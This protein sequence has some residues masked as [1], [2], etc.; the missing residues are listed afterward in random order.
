MLDRRFPSLSAAPAKQPRGPLRGLLRRRESVV[1]RSRSHGPRV[2]TS[3][4][5]PKTHLIVLVLDRPPAAAG[6][7][8][9]QTHPL[10]CYRN[11]GGG[12]DKEKKGGKGNGSA[13]DVVA[14][15][16]EKGWVG[17]GVGVQGDGDVGD[18]KICPG[19]QEAG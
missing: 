15:E 2:S 4:T 14:S 9:E 5:R 3:S 6:E 1:R 8:V 17:W 18:V 7:E 12:D 10:W 11:E 16:R 13:L 19:S